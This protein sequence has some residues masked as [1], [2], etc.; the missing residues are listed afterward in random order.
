MVM[1]E[2]REKESPSNWQLRNDFKTKV[3]YN[4]GKGETLASKVS[5]GR[6]RMLVNV[7]HELRGPSSS[8]VENLAN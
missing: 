2:S 7:W 6:H 8:H 1:D 4:G 3:L 5:T